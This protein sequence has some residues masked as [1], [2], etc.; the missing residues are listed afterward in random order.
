MGMM[1]RRISGSTR[2]SFDRAHGIL[3]APQTRAR[4]KAATQQRRGRA[5]YYCCWYVQAAA[6]GGEGTLCVVSSVE[7]LSGVDCSVER[8]EEFGLPAES[9]RRIHSQTSNPTPQ[10]ILRAFSRFRCV[11]RF[12]VVKRNPTFSD[13]HFL[14][15]ITK[16]TSCCFLLSL[17]Y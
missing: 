2:L 1:M 16:L 17:F 4:E 12:V 13:G 7:C 11:W 5:H 3:G 15:G 10:V 14:V 9:D 8:G 6:V